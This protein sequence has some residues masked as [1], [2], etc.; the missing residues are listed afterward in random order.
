MI[1]KKL[2]FVVVICASAFINRVE[3]QVF[4]GLK[5][6]SMPDSIAYGEDMTIDLTIVNYGSHCDSLKTNIL[7]LN[8][9][10]IHLSSNADSIGIDSVI[11]YWYIYDFNGNLNH[12]S[13]NSSATV[14]LPLTPTLDTIIACLYIEDNSINNT[15]SACNICDTLVFDGTSW[16]TTASIISTQPLYH[17]IDL[18]FGSISLENTNSTF[19]PIYLPVSIYPPFGFTTGDSIDISVSFLNVNQFSFLQTG[20]NIVIIWPSSIDPISADTS[21]TPI[22]VQSN[23]VFIKENDLEE[24]DDFRV[25]DLLGREYF[26]SS[27]LLDGV[28]YIRNGKKF[29]YKK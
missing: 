12:Q 3:A 20:G 9:Y 26:N 28:V 11:Y 17:P 27:K 13:F 14:V 7:T 16:V 2:F 8:Q 25:F 5:N 24:Y 6:I 15:F 22:V 23:T 19:V 1:Y 4:L 18:N 10:L 21:Y 29:I